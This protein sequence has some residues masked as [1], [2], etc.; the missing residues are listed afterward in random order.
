MTLVQFFIVLCMTFDVFMAQDNL[1]PADITIERVEECENPELYPAK[2]PAQMNKINRTHAGFTACLNMP[3]EM[4]EN[5]SFNMTAAKWG[6]GGWKPNAFNFYQ[7][8]T[9]KMLKTSVEEPWIIF[10]KA[11]GYDG[12]LCPIPKGNYC[13]EKLVFPLEG[14]FPSMLYGKFRVDAEFWWQNKPYMCVRGYVNSVPSKSP[15]GLKNYIK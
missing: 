1:G 6:D 5:S 11:S 8:D 3:E 14:L 12:E 7:V 10:L 15:K 4:G 2:L 9:C 13:I